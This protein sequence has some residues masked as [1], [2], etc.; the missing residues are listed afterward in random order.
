[1]AGPRTELLITLLDQKA[2]WKLGALYRREVGERLQGGNRKLIRDLVLG[3]PLFLK[4][5]N[6]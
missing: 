4:E 6:E 1:M 5:T 3:A 2:V